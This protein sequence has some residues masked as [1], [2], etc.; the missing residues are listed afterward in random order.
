MSLFYESDFRFLPADALVFEDVEVV[1]VP[2]GYF[3][4]VELGALSV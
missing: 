3:G 1:V 2:A 4:P